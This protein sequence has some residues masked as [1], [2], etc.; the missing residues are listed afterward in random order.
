MRT[1]IIRAKISSPNY[2]IEHTLRLRK[3][4]NKSGSSH[5][6]PKLGLHYELSESSSYNHVRHKPVFEFI[7]VVL[8]GLPKMNDG[9]EHPGFIRLR[10]S[11][12]EAIQ[13]KFK[14]VYYVWSHESTRGTMTVSFFYQHSV[15]IL[16]LEW[17]LLMFWM[18][19]LLLVDRFVEIRAHSWLNGMPRRYAFQKNVVGKS[20]P[21]CRKILHRMVLE[22]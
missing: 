2:R 16:S 4:L 21:N 18:S 19:L 8:R 6:D 1:S 10:Y 14:A 5:L 9:I 3:S 22:T 7:D 12:S 15:C 13:S 17:Q 11:E 20:R